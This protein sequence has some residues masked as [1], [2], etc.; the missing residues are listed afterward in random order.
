MTAF[1]GVETGRQNAIDTEAAQGT[2]KYMGLI[3]RFSA[4]SQSRAAKIIMVEEL[5]VI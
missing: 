2:I 5:E 1:G 3:P 4:M